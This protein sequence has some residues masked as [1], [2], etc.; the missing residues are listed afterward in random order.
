[1][2]CINL[3]P[4]VLSLVMLQYRMSNHVY[5][6]VFMNMIVKQLST[7]V[8]TKYVRCLPSFVQQVVSNLLEMFEQVRYAIEKILVS[9]FSIMMLMKFLFL[10]PTITC[11]TTSV[12]S[13]KQEQETSTSAELTSTDKGM[14]SI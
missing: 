12:M 14:C 8:L 2:H 7:T 13:T 5:G 10:E 6:N 3:T 9:L 4:G 1:M 11:S